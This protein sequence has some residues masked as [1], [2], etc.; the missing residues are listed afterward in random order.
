MLEVKRNL[1]EK[2]IFNTNY[3]VRSVSFV[4]PYFGWKLNNFLYN[5]GWSD[6]TYINGYRRVTLI[7]K[8]MVK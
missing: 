8:R 6:T 7:R 2:N 5:L 4:L 1:T 3:K